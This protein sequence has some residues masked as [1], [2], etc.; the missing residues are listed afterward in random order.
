MQIRGFFLIA[1]TNIASTL[2]NWLP[3]QI[4][5]LVLTRFLGGSRRLF[6][7]KKLPFSGCCNLAGDDYFCLFQH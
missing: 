7:E 2:G 5:P 4:N 1:G 3:L 6:Y